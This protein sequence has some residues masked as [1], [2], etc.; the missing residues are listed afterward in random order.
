MVCRGVQQ[1]LPQCPKPRVLQHPA[2][3]SCFV[4]FSV[5]E[6][7][8][9]SWQS[10]LPCCSLTRGYASLRHAEFP[11]PIMSWRRPCL[12]RPTPR[13]LNF[14]VDATH[15][16]LA[17]Y[18][19]GRIALRSSASHCLHLSKLLSTIL[20]E[21]QRFGLH[22]CPRRPVKRQAGTIH[23]ALMHFSSHLNFGFLAASLFIYF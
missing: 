19:H 1:L 17:L 21:R 16:E 13:S 23:L 11:D 10:R 15:R 3:P 18:A 20:Q 5:K 6:V 2:P 4:S 7:A 8:P 12:F 14:F 22:P 9:S